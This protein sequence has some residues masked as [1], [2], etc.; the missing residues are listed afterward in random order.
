ML[1]LART[2]TKINKCFISIPCTATEIAGKLRNP[3]IDQRALNTNLTPDIESR[4]V[5]ALP[6][7]RS[8][9]AA[10]DVM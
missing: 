1:T 3:K 10:G 2:K 8:A 9:R 7:M 6:A 5:E 4:L